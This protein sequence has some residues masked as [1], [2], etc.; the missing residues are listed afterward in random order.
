MATNKPQG[1]LVGWRTDKKYFPLG[2]TIGISST[3]ETAYPTHAGCEIRAHDIPVMQ[4][5]FLHRG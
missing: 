2:K 3:D 1:D 5:W 4:C